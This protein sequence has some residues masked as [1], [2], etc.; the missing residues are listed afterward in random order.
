[1]T[2]KKVTVVTLESLKRYAQ[3]SHDSNPIHQDEKAAKEMGLPGVIAHGMWIAGLIGE[4]AVQ[5]QKAFLPHHR[6]ISSETRFQG[7]AFLGDEIW[8]ELEVKEKE[9]IELKALNQKKELLC[10][11]FYLFSKA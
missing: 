7:M 2:S 5:Y 10:S 8:I 11:A 3:V 9:K 4:E 1:M 6:M